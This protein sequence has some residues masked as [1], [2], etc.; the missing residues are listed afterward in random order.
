MRGASLVLVLA[1]AVAGTPARAAADHPDL[2]AGRAQLEQAEFEAALAALERAAR[3]DDL[4]RADVVELFELRALA[5]V[6]LADVSALDRDIAALASIAPDHRFPPEAP[7]ELQVMLDREAE[8]AGR[9]AVVGASVGTAAGVRLDAEVEND[10]GGIVRAVR[11]HVR[12]GER[13]RTL[14]P[15]TSVNASVRSYYVEAIGPGGAVVASHGSREVPL[16]VETEGAAAVEWPDVFGNQGERDDDGGE[17][18][19]WLWVGIG[20]GVAVA[21]GVVLLVVLLSGSEGTQP[22]APVVLGF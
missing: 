2:D 3:S 9:L 8:A 19:P 20:A 16:A 22:E 7:P 14:E 18:G 1:A 11:V 12:E 6:A 5:H 4:R 13:W 21:L 17:E 15:G 10:E